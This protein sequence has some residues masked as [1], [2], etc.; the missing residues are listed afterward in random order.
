MLTILAIPISYLL[1]HLAIKSYNEYHYKKLCSEAYHNINKADSIA[2]VI[3]KLHPPGEGQLNEDAMKIVEYSAERGN[4]KSSVMLGRYYKYG[5]MTEEYNGIDPVSFPSEYCST[6]CSYYY[7]QAALK[8]NAEAQGELGNNYKYGIGV[9]I[10]LT[11][12]LYWLKKGADNGDPL[13]QYRLGN[14]Y[15]TG[16]AVYSIGYKNYIYIGDNIFVSTDNSR[17]EVS[18][19]ILTNILKQ[20]FK[21]YVKPNLKLTKYYWELAAKGGLEVAKYDL[22]KIM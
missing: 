18:D 7:L 22:I 3:T 11:K 15:Y 4:I 20:P 6:R 9:K 14:L 2:W 16:L 17:H 12:A 10:N 21:V 1:G 8:G 13:A 19:E 5:N